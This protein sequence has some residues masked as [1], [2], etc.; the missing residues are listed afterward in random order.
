[1]I[2]ITAKFHGDAPGEVQDQLCLPFELRHKRWLVTVLVSGEDVALRLPRGAKLRGG[3]LLL[4]S[5]GRVVEVVA[6]FERVVHIECATTNELVRVAYHL[7]NRHIPVQ[8][9]DG[10]LRIL[11][12]SVIE[13]MLGGLGARITTIE[14]PFEPEAGAYAGADL[15]GGVSHDGAT[16]KRPFTGSEPS[17]E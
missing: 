14:A 16:R 13:A 8:V 4:A 6:A 10:Y 15:V 1:M 12:D 17:R 3:D 2:E 9:G 5:D 11:T 7:G